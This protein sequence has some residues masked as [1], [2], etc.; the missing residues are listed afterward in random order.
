MLKVKFM[1]LDEAFKILNMAGIIVEDT[2]TD[3]E[4]F[5]ELRRQYK[6]P[7]GL[8]GKKLRR[9]MSLIKDRSLA[10]KI[11]NAKKFNH[12]YRDELR[13]MIKDLNNGQCGA[14]KFRFVSHDPEYYTVV[15]ENHELSGD[16]ERIDEIEW[17]WYPDDGTVYATYYQSGYNVSTPLDSDRFS[18]TY[19][20]QEFMDVIRDDKQIW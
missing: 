15:G 13:E 16:D 17:E 20:V 5:E 1:R 7:K 10:A 9:Y 11:A 3:E 14:W 12:S 19:T 4:E 2:D 18:D 8:S 6:T